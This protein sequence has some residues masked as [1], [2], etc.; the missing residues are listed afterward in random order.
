MIKIKMVTG[1]ASNGM[2]EGETCIVALMALQEEPRNLYFYT[3]LERGLLRE[4]NYLFLRLNRELIVKNEDPRQTS[5]LVK[6]AH[7]MGTF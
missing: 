2:S 3:C 1:M 4:I 7:I 6:Q 5:E